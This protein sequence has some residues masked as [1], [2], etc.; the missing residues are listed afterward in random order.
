MAVEHGRSNRLVVDQLEIGP[1]DRV[2]DVGCGPG[3]ALV[4]ACVRAERGFVAGVDPSAV[5]VGQ[6]RRRVRRAIVSG[7]AE[8]KHAVAEAI[9]YPDGSFTRALSIYSLDH[10]DSILAGLAELH[11]VLVAGGRVSI[12]VRRERPDVSPRA[13]HHGAGEAEIAELQRLLHG[14]G[15]TGI[16]IQDHHLGRETLAIVSAVR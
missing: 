11:R 14:L 3:V 6:A 16:A 13:H 10:W 2:L 7:R 9:P 12:A 1:E 5:M 8:V 15:F 4:A